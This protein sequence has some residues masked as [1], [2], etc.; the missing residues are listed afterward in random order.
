MTELSHAKPA[1]F[2]DALH[3]GPPG[4]GAILQ[5]H[6]DDLDQQHDAS[7]LG[8][9][10][11]LATEV[12]FFGGLFAAYAV[13]RYI[14]FDAFAAA[15]HHLN[16]T[17]GAFNT[18]VL[19]TSSLTM[20][21]AVRA[22]QLRRRTELVQFLGLTMVLGGA[23]LGIKAYEWHKDY[24]EHLVPGVNFRW[25]GKQIGR[26][27]LPDPPRPGDG[28]IRAV[29]E[30]YPD[31]LE[32]AGSAKVGPTPTSELGR[33]V[34][35]YFVLYFFM[36]GLHAFHMIIGIAM[37][38]IMAALA[39]RGWFSG[40]GVTQIEVAGLYWH[41]VDLVWVFLYPLLYLIQVKS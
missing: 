37:M 1:P 17:L 2:V 41:F 7:T 36:T 25:E 30:Q 6:F 22:A 23:F 24:E 27:G 29:L 26:Y 15:T 34:Q 11:F 12:M 35:L 33:A 32:H 21:L 31:L 19:L 4:D 9:W 38:A 8:M 13:Y 20:A 16:V 10:A 39:W 5:H 28:N 40:G 14:H 18:L 3:E